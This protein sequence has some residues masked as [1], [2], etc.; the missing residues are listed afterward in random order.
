[1]IIGIAFRSFQCNR[2]RVFLVHDESQGAAHALFLAR[3][4]RIDGSRDK[5]LYA[6]EVRGKRE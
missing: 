1:M 5:Y 2:K 3:C 6:G 4:E